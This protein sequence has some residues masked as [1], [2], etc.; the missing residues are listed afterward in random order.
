MGRYYAHT[1]SLPYRFA[2]INAK[3]RKDNIIFIF[4]I[5]QLQK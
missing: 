4:N 2:F 3:T 5:G 1:V